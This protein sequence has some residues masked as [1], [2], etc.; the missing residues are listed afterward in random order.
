[1]SADECGWLFLVPML[2]SQC[3]SVRISD[4]HYGHLHHR[5]ALLVPRREA[6]RASCAS[7]AP[8][9][10]SVRRHSRI[11]LKKKKK[12][13]LKSLHVIDVACNLFVSVLGTG[14]TSFVRLLRRPLPRILLLALRQVPFD[15]MSIPL[16]ELAIV[17]TTTLVAVLRRQ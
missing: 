5:R 3:G 17:I 10:F 13:L 16:A 1:M 9:G 15:Q 8:V 14:G 7:Q 12:L 11:C 2:D 6:G 4:D